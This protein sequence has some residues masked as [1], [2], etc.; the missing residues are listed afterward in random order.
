[1][2]IPTLPPQKETPSDPKALFTRDGKRAKLVLASIETG[3]NI[4]DQKKSIQNTLADIGFEI[5]TREISPDNESIQT[6]LK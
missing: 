4:A 5:E 2:T 6:L 1:M 3:E